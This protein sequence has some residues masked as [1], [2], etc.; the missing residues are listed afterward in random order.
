M[1]SCRVG[2]V[3]LH[4]RLQTIGA[5]AIGLCIAAFVEPGLH[6]RSVGAECDL[7]V[8]KVRG[9]GIEIDVVVVRRE[10]HAVLFAERGQRGET[11]VG[12]RPSDWAERS[13]ADGSRSPSAAS[14]A[15]PPSRPSAR[16]GRR[17]LSAAADGVEVAAPEVEDEAAGEFADAAGGMQSVDVAPDSSPRP[18][19]CGRG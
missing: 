8:G 4:G 19:R 6:R 12:C 5:P 7:V 2:D 13:R 16:S 11:S 3:G 9:V 14:C 10:Q 17:A 1:S 18:R 15:R